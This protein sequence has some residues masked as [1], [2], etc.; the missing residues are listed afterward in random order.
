MSAGSPAGSVSAG[1]GGLF[2]Q[3]GGGSAVARA[4]RMHL[5]H[6]AGPSKKGQE[7]CSRPR[8]LIE[9]ALVQRSRSHLGAGASKWKREHY[10]ME[11]RLA[12]TQHTQAEGSRAFTSC[13]IACH[14]NAASSA[15][16]PDVSRCVMET[17][18]SNQV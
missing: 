14:E 2:R 6:S 15:S 3:I 17:R 12:V 1:L 8:P 16:A 18:A 13:L 7:V 5:R 9:L 10:F 11:T 4:D